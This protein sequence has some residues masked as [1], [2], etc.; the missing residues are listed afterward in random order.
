M[1]PSFYVAYV[2]CVGVL[3]SVLPSQKVLSRPLPEINPVSKAS[4]YNCYVVTNEGRAFDLASLCGGNASKTQEVLRGKQILNKAGRST[5]SNKQNQVFN[6][7]S[8]ASTK[9]Q[10]SFQ[11]PSKW[12]WLPE[13]FAIAQQEVTITQQGVSGSSNGSS[14]S[15]STGTRGNCNS[16]DDIA[17]DGKRCGGRSSESRPGGR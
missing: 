9:M 2:A 15:S 4:A 10:Q 12:G 6:S 8:T 7:V 17:A 1:K 13:S 16:P 3:L 11:Q 5:P 14:S